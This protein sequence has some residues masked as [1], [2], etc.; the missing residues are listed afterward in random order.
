MKK[1]A[2][3]EK[4]ENV[5]KEMFDKFKYGLDVNEDE[6]DTWQTVTRHLIR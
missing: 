4:M 6:M 2:L 5:Q 1:I 3:K